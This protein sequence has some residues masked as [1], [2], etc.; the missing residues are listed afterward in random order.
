MAHSLSRSVPFLRYQMLK[1]PLV[2]D[3]IRHTLLISPP[4]QQVRVGVAGLTSS[5]SSLRW[6]SM[7]CREVG[8]LTVRHPR[9]LFTEA[10]VRKMSFFT[11]CNFCPVATV[12]L[13]V[14]L[15]S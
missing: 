11:V 15:P 4:L 8:W 14:F 6:L 10:G 3:E 13:F 1:H 5:D 9:K 12:N 7:L 2:L